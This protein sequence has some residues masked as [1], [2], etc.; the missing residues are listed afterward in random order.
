[1]PG[2]QADTE[3]GR[4]VFSEDGNLFDAIIH[5]PYAG[6]SGGEESHIALTKSPFFAFLGP[7]EHLSGDDDN[8]LVLAVMPIEASGSALPDHNIRSAVMALRQ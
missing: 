5:T 6:T 4:Q 3:W 1:M 8:R 2:S 7:N